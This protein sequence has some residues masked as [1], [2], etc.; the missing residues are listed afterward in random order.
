MVA[1]IAELAAHVQSAW[2]LKQQTYVETSNFWKVLSRVARQT[3]SPVQRLEDM[4][5]FLDGQR[6]PLSESQRATRQGEYPYYGASGIIDHIDDYIFDEPLLL[7]SEDGA[8][9]V[10]RSTP[11]AFA[12]TGKYW[13]NNHAHVLRPLD[14]VADLYFLAYALSDY[15]V[16]SLN[17]ASAQAQLN[18]RNACAIQFPLPPIAEQRR[19]VGALESLQA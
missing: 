10:N 7:L 19:L 1:R 9:L 5:E 2:S 12:V 11:I 3:D 8:N 6:V 14:G 16:G 4:V 15:D 18:Q 13:V 17:F